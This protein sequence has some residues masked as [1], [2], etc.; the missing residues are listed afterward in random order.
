MKIIE[1]AFAWLPSMLVLTWRCYDIFTCFDSVIVVVIGY[2][3]SSLC[4]IEQLVACDT[5]ANVKPC[6]VGCR[7]GSVHVNSILVFRLKF[8][9]ISNLFSLFAVIF[10]FTYLYIEYKLVLVTGQ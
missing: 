10:S 2:V 6:A 7:K 3:E 5:A 8:M 9:V 4:H 1:G